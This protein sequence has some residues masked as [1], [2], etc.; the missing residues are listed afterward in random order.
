MTHTTQSSAL[1]YLRDNRGEGDINQI[2]SDVAA[3]LLLMKLVQV[4]ASDKPGINIRLTSKG[5]R[6]AMGA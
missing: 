5:R 1:C 3:F 6:Y 2:S 4:F